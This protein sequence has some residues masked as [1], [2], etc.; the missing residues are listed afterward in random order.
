MELWLGRARR[1]L[2]DW[3]E[4]RQGGERVNAN[5]SFQMLGWEE[6]KGRDVKIQIEKYLLSRKNQAQNWKDRAEKRE[7]IELKACDPELSLFQEWGRKREGVNKMGLVLGVRSRKQ[8][9]FYPTVSVISKK[10]KWLFAKSVRGAWGDMDLKIWEIWQGC[11]AE[12]DRAV[13]RRNDDC[14]ASLNSHPMNLHTAQ[15]W[16]SPAVVGILGR[17]TVKDK[18]NFPGF[19]Q[20]IG[21]K[22]ANKMKRL[23]IPGGVTEV[24]Y[25]TIRVEREEDENI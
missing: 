14:L 5:K 20:I 23:R 12:W 2:V 11:S 10:N 25:Y 7:L 24:I 8:R 17:Y 9:C 1:C 15:S 3:W 4:K 22:K 21:Y 19:S 16:F 6:W 13:S 18:K